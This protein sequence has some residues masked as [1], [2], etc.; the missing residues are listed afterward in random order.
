VLG[1]IAGLVILLSILGMY[2]ILLMLLKA[3]ERELGIRKVH[4]ASKNDLFKLFSF[5]FF[6]IL[7]IG[8]VCSI[9]IFWMGINNWLEKYP[10]RISLSPFYFIGTALLILLVA[11]LVVYVQASRA[12]QANTVDALK[13]E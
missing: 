7:L 4:G 6:K 12:Y 8:I 9:P 5:D 10:L 2:A 13:N 11:G 3:R 1:I